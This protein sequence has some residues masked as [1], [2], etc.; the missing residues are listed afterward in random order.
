MT[1]LL[2][3]TE[4]TA[5][6]DKLTEAI[7][8]D[9]PTE[10]GEIALIGI[11]SRGELLACRLAERLARRLGTELPYGALDITLYRDDLEQAEP[12]R[13]PAVR[14]TEIPFDIEGRFI[15]LVDD[16][17]NTGRSVRAA[18]NALADLGRPQ[19]IRLA[20]LVD[21]GRRELPIR[22]DYVGMETTVPIEQRVNVFL[23]ETDGRDEV[24]VE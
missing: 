1:T 3:E 23:Q 11:R 24:V 2:T 5:L 22:A 20:V 17:L 9:C 12:D 7:A 15:I 10:Y 21:R 4:I 8:A 18:L 14:T 16:V 19:A 6:L 13:Q